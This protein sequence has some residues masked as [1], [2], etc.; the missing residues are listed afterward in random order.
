MTN[1]TNPE[2]RL[3]RLKNAAEYLAL[4]PWT[5]RRLVQ[6]VQIPVV[7]YGENAAWL[8]DRLRRQPQR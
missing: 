2:R 8:L 6:E 5:L 4:S 1:L 3:L 7:R